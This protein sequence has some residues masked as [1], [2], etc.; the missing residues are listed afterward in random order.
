VADIEFLTVTEVA[1]LLR[2]HPQVVQRKL[3]SGEI[4]GF[5]IGREWRVERGQLLEWVAGHSN[6]RAGR[7]AGH[8]WFDAV[9]KLKTL[10]AARS[11]RTAVLER[12]ATAFEPGRAYKETEVNEVLRRFHDD[13]ATLRR[14]L[15]AEKLL[16]RRPGGPYKLAGP[17]Q[18]VV[19]RA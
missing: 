6:Q 16:V 5:R 14:E 3:Q 1:E 12:I 18:P 8:E 11:K 2:F 4:P 9:G 13:V 19:R 15:V 10:P 7:A 17:R